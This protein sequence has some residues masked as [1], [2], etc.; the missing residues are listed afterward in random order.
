MA[1]RIYGVLG[2]SYADNFYGAM[3]TVV[4][5]RASESL[6]LT[7]GVEAFRSQGIAVTG[8]W[9]SRLP[10]G[11]QRWFLYNRYL[12]RL[13]SRWNLSEFSTHVAFGYESP[14]W[15]LTLGMANRFM[16]PFRPYDQT[17]S[18]DYVFEPF[19]LMYEARYTLDFG[20]EKRWNILARLTNYDDFVTD[21]G[22]QPMLTIGGGHYFVDRLK[23]YGEVV[24]YPT[25]MWSLSA[26]YYELF[27]KLGLSKQW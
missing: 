9:Q 18:T 16:S 11:S 3:A 1:G 22:Y 6:V 5:Y 15:H 14:H 13:F 27:F 26:N 17:G 7:G 2:H 8:A 4:D 12:Y 24:Y 21:R 23:L 25:G 20:R 19:N 10:F